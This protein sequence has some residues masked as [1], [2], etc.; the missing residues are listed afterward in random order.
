MHQ[1][2][3][4]LS[5]IALKIALTELTVYPECKTKNDIGFICAVNLLPWKMFSCTQHLSTDGLRHQRYI[6]FISLFFQFSIKWILT[7]LSSLLLRFALSKF[8]QHFRE[9][10]Y[11]L[12]SVWWKYNHLTCFILIYQIQC[13][14]F[15]ETANGRNAYNLHCFIF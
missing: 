2:F 4:S 13:R 1:S 9:T 8:V 12:Y 14:I 15:P 7:I 3:S 6:F 11:I 10:F 5:D